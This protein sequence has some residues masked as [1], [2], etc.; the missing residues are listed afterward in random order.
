MFTE[1]AVGDRFSW[2]LKLTSVAE[3]PT[4]AH[5][6]EQ[7]ALRGWPRRRRVA[8]PARGNVLRGARPDPLRAGG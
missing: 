6:L 1:Y 7:F 8:S 5:V 4:A 2:H 3:K